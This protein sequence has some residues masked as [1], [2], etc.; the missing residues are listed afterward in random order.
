MR[1]Q[2]K[3]LLVVMTS[4]LALIAIA[5][6]S[7][8]ALACT[9]AGGAMNVD[10]EAD[11]DMTLRVDPG[12]SDIELRDALGGGTEITPCSGGQPTLTN[13]ASVTITGGAGNVQMMVDLTTGLLAG[14]TG[15]PAEAGTPEIELTVDGG[16]GGDQLT[17]IG[18]PVA[19]NFTFGA[20]AVGHSANFNGDDDVDDLVLQNI[21]VLELGMG[22][23]NDAISLNGGPGFVGPVVINT[24]AF[25]HGSFGHDTMTGTP[26]SNQIDSDDGDDTIAGLGGDDAITTDAGDDTVDY[27]VGSTG[28]I[29]LDLG[30]TNTGQATGGAGTDTLITPGPENLTGSPF[31]D[32]LTGTAA[33][34]RIVGLGGVDTLTLLGGVDFFDVHDGGPDTVDCGAP[35]DSGIAD[36]PGVD[37][38]TNC[39]AVN[40]G[41]QTTIASGP[42]DGETVTTSTPT[43]SLT[44]S[45]A[46][47][48]AFSVDGGSFQAC[49]ASCQVSPLAVGVHAL[50]FRTTDGTGLTDLTPATRSV[51]VAA[52]TLAPP[53]LAPAVPS[54]TGQRAAALK[55]C[56]KKKSKKKRKK[57]R[58]KA[59][60]LPV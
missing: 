31:G 37:T 18:T 26:N 42:A 58:R 21:D 10:P 43:Y 5:P 33:P 54:V 13:T 17:L 15:G 60:K 19:D 41:P 9:F 36:E 8:S 40:H 11:P 7:A 35:G 25:V 39:E 16:T 55:K 32:N 50:S 28:G 20:Q 3:G 29:T 46:A 49:A 34:N 22:A 45:E 47:S 57:C 12:G 44:S 24:G 52:P 14:G 2:G 48:F 4:A 59:Q 23:G 6:S 1:R 53:T 56:K 51:V 38:L 30:V 27:S